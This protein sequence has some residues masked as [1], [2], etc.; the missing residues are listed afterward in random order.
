MLF[1]LAVA[2]HSSSVQTLSAPGFR[3]IWEL[4]TVDIPVAMRIMK[5]RGK[6]TEK[7]AGTC[8]ILGELN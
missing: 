4:Q 6:A 5:S 8:F 2:M 1:T 7:E 3:T